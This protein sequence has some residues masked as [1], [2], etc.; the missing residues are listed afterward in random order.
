MVTALTLVALLAV[1]FFP[2]GGD[3]RNLGL[4]EREGEEKV[5]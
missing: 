3:S 2:F 4:D 5:G 1:V